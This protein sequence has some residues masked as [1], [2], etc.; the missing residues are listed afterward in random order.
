MAKPIKITILGDASQFRREVSGV[1]DRLGSFAGSAV[2]TAGIATVALGGLAAVGGAHLFGVGEDLVSLDTKINTVFSGQSLDQVSTWA[3][4]VAARMGLTSTQAQ[5]LAANAADLLKPMGFTADQAASMSTEI[6]G[7]S[8]ALS[9]WSGGQRSVD[10]TA[11]ILQKALLGERESLKELGISINQAEVDARALTVAQADGRDEI[12]AMDKAAATQQLIFEK[13]ADAQ[14]AYAAGGNELTAAQNKLK[15]TVGDLQEKVARKLLPVMTDL[16]TFVADD[17]VPVIEEQLPKAFEFLKTEV[18]PVVRDMAD[19]IRTA[20]GA[21]VRWTRTNW[22]EIQ[23]VITA[24][25]DRIQTVVTVVLDAVRIA[26]ETWG[27]DVLTV[28]RDTV[29]PTIDLIKAVVQT[30]EGLI[31]FVV[32]VFTGDW[33][34]AWDGIK[35]TVDGVV[36]AVT[37]ALELLWIRLKFI[38]SVGID[39]IR[40]LWNWSFLSDWVSTAVDA[41]V[42][43]FSDLPGRF[44]GLVEDVLGA[45]KSLGSAIIDGIADGVSGAA[46]FVADFASGL[47]GAITGLINAQV[48]DRVNSLLEFSVSLGP[49]GSITIDPPDIP[50]LASGGS[51]SG[52]ALVGERG[53]EL[54]SGVGTVR[55]AAETRHARSG[56]GVEVVNNFYG[57]QS[58]A[59]I[60]ASM[61]WSLRGSAL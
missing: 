38:V 2:K 34:R 26:W 7:L 58:P 50:R 16:A 10:D 28:L 27:D 19:V 17:V 30:L 22:P 32:G 8:G 37:A 21:V 40:L 44:D 46:G 52:L 6:V 51:F 12:T 24:V 13:S 3:D 15:A 60:E 35:A 57:P 39:T 1:S 49:L 47:V 20:F 11:R 4:T 5:G 48:I 14:A 41:V 59:E 25:V 55:S 9:E 56:R 29:G 33:G 18:V 45:G 42:G 31:D 43:F 54:V 61:L 23:R 36:D 53:P